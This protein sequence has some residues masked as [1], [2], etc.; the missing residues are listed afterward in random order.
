MKF[1]LAVL[2]LGIIGK[3]TASEKEASATRNEKSK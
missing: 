3:I 1:I 2:F